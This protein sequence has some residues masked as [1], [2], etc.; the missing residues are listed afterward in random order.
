MLVAKYK[1]NANIESNNFLVK[2]VYHNIK[3]AVG[4]FLFYEIGNCY[5]FVLPQIRR[6][7]I[8]GQ[9]LDDNQKLERSFGR[10]LW[11]LTDE[12]WHFGH[13]FVPSNGRRMCYAVRWWS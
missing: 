6:V 11:H 5:I 9:S 10:N 3:N 13:L 4:L 1:I 8:V 2:Q 12:N 7:W